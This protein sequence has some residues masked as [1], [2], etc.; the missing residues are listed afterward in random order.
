VVKPPYQ[1][2]QHPDVL[3]RRHLSV[4]S[5]WVLSS[6]ED[7]F[8]HIHSAETRH[9]L[10]KQHVKVMSQVRLLEFTFHVCDLLAFIFFCGMGSWS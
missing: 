1:Q 5:K 9:K 4:S 10:H 3:V 6:S 7:T 2:K 8:C